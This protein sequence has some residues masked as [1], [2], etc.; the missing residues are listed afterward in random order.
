[1]MN[2]VIS[3]V[4]CLVLCTCCAGRLASHADQRKMQR[5]NPA[6][7]PASAPEVFAESSRQGPG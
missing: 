1:M 2:S 3:A 5:S 6:E 4:F 7:I